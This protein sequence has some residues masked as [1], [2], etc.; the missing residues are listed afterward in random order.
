MLSI[1][2]LRALRNEIRNLCSAVAILKD[3]VSNGLGM[4]DFENI[5]DNINMLIDKIDYTSEIYKT[6]SEEICETEQEIEISLL[7][8]DI[9]SLFI[10]LKYSLKSKHTKVSFDDIYNCL[11]FI[12]KYLQEALA[13][14]VKIVKIYSEDNVYPI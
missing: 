8:Q 9:K 14:A 3:A 6:L 12:F 7:L 13:Y 11:N 4:S 1:Q 2:Q 10:I 5:Q